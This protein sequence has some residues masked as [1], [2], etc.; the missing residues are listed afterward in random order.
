MEDYLVI[1]SYEKKTDS[2]ISVTK[3]VKVFV[4]EKNFNGWWLVDTKEGQGFV[5]QIIL[6][7]KCEF[8]QIVLEK[9]N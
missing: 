9:G 7:K 6:E 3:G 1:R 8:E 4:I 2:D 5:P